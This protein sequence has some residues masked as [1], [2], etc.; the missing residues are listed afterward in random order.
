M[1]IFG[2]PF[3]KWGNMFFK[4]RRLLSARV[5]LSTIAFG[6]DATVGIAH[7]ARDKEFTN[8]DVY[9]GIQINVRFLFAIFSVLIPVQKTDSYLP[10]VEGQ[11][12]IATEQEP[13][14]ADKVH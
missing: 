6:V 11:A 4:I 10:E 14:Q 12:S 8:I 9:E 3:L 1:I 13:K 7:L 5:D 2:R